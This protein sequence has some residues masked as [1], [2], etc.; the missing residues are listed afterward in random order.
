MTNTY[1]IIKTIINNKKIYYYLILEEKKR[2]VII[3]IGGL[4]NQCIRIIINKKAKIGYIEDLVYKK[5]CSIFNEINKGSESSKNSIALL[6]KCSLIFCINKYPEVS[7]YKI[8]DMSYIQCSNYQRISLSDLYVIKYNKSWYEKIFNA[9]PVEEQIKDVERGKELILEKLNSEIN[10]DLEEF[11]NRYY[12][13]TKS[14][15]INKNLEHIKIAYKKNIKVKDYLSYFL[16]NNLDCRLYLL[17]F[18]MIFGYIMYGKFWQI[19][20][21]VIKDYNINIESYETEYIDNHANLE[22]L[23][24]QLNEINNNHSSI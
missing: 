3:K 4:K 14:L 15:N 17:F 12:I 7:L 13:Y 6:L 21:K 16:N 9:E 2:E 18:Q 20:K 8:S 10:L 19:S 24:K 23:Y 5:E 1:F 22:N 11:I